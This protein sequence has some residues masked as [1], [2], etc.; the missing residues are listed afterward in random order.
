MV[1]HSLNYVSW[2]QRKEVTADLCRIYTAT[3]VEEA[4]LELD[5]FAGKWDQQMPS[6]SQLWRRNWE[7]LTPFFA[8]PADIRKVVY[9][10]NAIESLNMSLRKV[11]KN[12]GSSPIDKAAVKLLYMALKNI[13]KKWTMLIRDWKAALNRFSIV[14]EG[15]MP[16]D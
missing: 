12:R 2:K 14:F 7:R 4:E 6:I 15:R 8:Y 3:T 5:A 13:E 10:T 16:L 9:T 1:R 11:T